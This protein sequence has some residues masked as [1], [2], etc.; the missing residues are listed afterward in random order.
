MK[1]KGQLPSYF[2]CMFL[3]HPPLL[4]DTLFLSFPMVLFV[5]SG[6][7]ISFWDW[8]SPVLALSP[9]VELNTQHTASLTAQ[10]CLFPSELEIVPCDHTSAVR[11]PQTHR[12]QRI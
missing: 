5:F 8:G 12:E 9:G 2:E 6:I 4:Q 7:S 10:H 1:Q 11:D 3:S